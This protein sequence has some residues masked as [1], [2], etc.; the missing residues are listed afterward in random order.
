MRP[1]IRAQPQAPLMGMGALHAIVYLQLLCAEIKPNVQR[2]LH[3]YNLQRQGFTRL[4]DSQGHRRR[5]CSMPD[6]GA[7]FE[8]FANRGTVK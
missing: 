8:P 5:P 4:L 1:S 3:C 6:L 2:A 7:E